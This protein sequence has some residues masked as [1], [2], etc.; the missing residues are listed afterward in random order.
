VQEENPDELKMQSL[1]IREIYDSNG[2]RVIYNMVRDNVEMILGSLKGCN[3]FEAVKFH[4]GQI[5]ALEKFWG[6]IEMLY[7][8]GEK[9]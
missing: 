5:N 8:E 4:Q 7:N 3:S 6:A 9:E 1:A 2:M